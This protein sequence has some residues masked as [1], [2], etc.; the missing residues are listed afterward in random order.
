MPNQLP[1][2]SSSA[3]SES[4]DGRPARRSGFSGISLAVESV[5]RR[6]GRAQTHVVPLE[7]TVET[8]AGLA[9]GRTPSLSLGRFVPTGLSGSAAPCYALP[10]RIYRLR[11]LEHSQLNPIAM[12]LESK[13]FA[14][15][16]L[17]A[18]SE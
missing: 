5:A 12:F 3:N 10:L 14:S 15:S 8:E 17:T 2:Q 4:I 13:G 1:P 11:G 6:S 9:W 16:A 18:S 7:N